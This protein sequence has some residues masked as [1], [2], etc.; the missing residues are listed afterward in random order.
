MGY[1]TE[2]R[3]QI[4]LDPSWYGLCWWSFLD[5]LWVWPLFRRSLWDLSSRLSNLERHRDRSRKYYE[6]TFTTNRLVYQRVTREQPSPQAKWQN[7]PFVW[8]GSSCRVSQLL[9]ITCV[10][11]GGFLSWWRREVFSF[12][13]VE[14]R[15]PWMRVAPGFPLG[16]K[17]VYI[18]GACYT[19]C[20]AFAVNRILLR[21]WR[22]V[23]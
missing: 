5:I 15:K 10:Q 13:K 20:W 18:S 9:R 7:I 14:V 11:Y 16:V 17:C 21:P 12:W 2:K 4:F 19:I 3:P 23:K 8:T 1:S 6:G 22:G